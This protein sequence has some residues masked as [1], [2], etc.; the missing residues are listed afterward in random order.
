MI[1]AAFEYVRPPNLTDAIAALTQHG[2]GAKLIAGGYSLLPMM[3]L[4]FAQP[5]TLIDIGG[6]SE[7]KGISVGADE[8]VIGAATTHAELEHD[9]RIAASLP[10]M[11][12][13]APL[14]AD[15]TV[16]NRGTLGGAIANSDPTADWPAAILAL[17]AMLDL[18]GPDGERSIAADGFFRG[19]F[20]NDLGPQEVLIRVRIPRRQG[21]R[22]SYRKFRHPASAHAVVGVAV[23]LHMRGENCTGG[24]IAVTGF[25][26]HAF[27]AKPAEAILAGYRGQPELSERIVEHAFEGVT[28]VED[29]FADAVY[30]LQVGRTMLRRALADAVA[31]LMNNVFVPP[32]GPMQPRNGAL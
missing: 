15:A 32:H 7:L 5:D 29:R 12:T 2:A 6:L 22:A 26:D 14:I 11:T 31:P 17:D 20:E 10:L 16:R 8:V 1:P 4:R 13:V 21:T 27:R 18:T 25:A 30:R 3:K 23:V 24:R 19:L 9:S 28:P